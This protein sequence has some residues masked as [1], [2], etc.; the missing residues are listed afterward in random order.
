MVSIMQNFKRNQNRKTL[1]ALFFAFIFGCVAAYAQ[2]IAVTGTVYDSKEEPVIG[3]TVSVVGTNKGVMTDIDGHFTIKTKAGSVLA[4]RYVGCKPQN[5]KVKNAGPLNITLEDN[6]QELNEVVVTAMG[7]TR[8]EKSL[9][10]ARQ[11]INPEN[12][13]ETRSAN[14]LDMLS[15]K[16]AGMQIISGGGPTASTRVVIRGLNSITGNN[17]PLYVIDGVPVMN[18]NGED[19]ELDFGNAVNAI[20]PDEIENIEVL[21]GANAS[22]LYGS[23]AANGVVLIT[24][25]KAAKANKGLGVTY[26]FN[27]MFGHLYNFPTYQNIY[28]TGQNGLFE[29]VST[30][31]NHYGAQN[32]QI[33]YDPNLPYFIYNPNMAGQSPNSWGMPMLGFEIV[34]RDGKVKPYSPNPSTIED[35]YQ[36]STMITNNVSIERKFDQGS[37]RLSYNNV[38]SDD[39]L[40]N[41][42]KLNRHTFNLRATAD[43]A[44]WVSVDVN[45]RYQYESVD[46]RAYRNASDR[47]PIYAIIGLA[48]DI[49]VAELTPWKKEDGTPF[50]FQGFNNPYWL[51]NEVDNGDSRHWFM[52]NLTLNFTITNFLKL[53]GR[54]ATDIQNSEGWGFTNMNTTFCRDGDYNNW[55]RNRSNNNFDALLMFNK[56]FVDNKFNVSANVGTSYQEIKGSRLK[57]SVTMLQFP[58]IKSLSNNKGQILSIQ[59][60]EWKKKLAVYGMAS[61]GWDNWAFLDLTARNE[62]S[63]TL[64]EKNNSYFYWS[65]GAGLV[66]NTLFKLDAHKFPYI[67]IRGSYA[68]VGN[69]T[70]Y[71]KLVSG[72]YKAEKNNTF[73]GISYYIGDDLLKT[74]DLK[75]ERTNSW[76]VGVD[77]R[78]LDGRIK[79]DAT[80]YSKVTRDQIIEADAPFASGYQKEMLNAGKMTNKGVELSLTATPLL[81]KN[82]S[83]I[84]TVNWSKNSNK[85]IELSPG[86]ERYEIGQAQFIKSYAEVGKS[87][88]VFYGNDFKRDENGNILVSTNGMAKYEE[89]QYLGE[90]QPDWFGGWSNTF[91]IFDFDLGFAIDFQKGGKVWSYTAFE[92]ARHGQTVQSLEGRYEYLLSK[93]ILGEDEIERWGFVNPTYTNDPNA[94]L[95]SHYYA[96]GDRSK[97]IYLEGVYDS[98]A[99]PELAGKKTVAWVRPEDYWNHG[100]RASARRYIYDASYVKLREISVGYNIPSKWLRKTK[101]LR[102]ARISFVGRNVAILFQNTPKG[103]D[104]QATSSTGNAQGFERGFNLPMATYGFDIKVTF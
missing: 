46:H 34:G 6:S 88:G 86:V 95:Y 83:W 18:N 76:E 38:H 15:G 8:D 16:A 93:L 24:T 78:F 47:N 57:S 91:K 20:N 40:R 71:D 36:T 63:S 59:E 3:A 60:N 13:T 90:I 62:W 14:L 96:D 55:K 68:Q 35:M 98:D 67:K 41:V 54:A 81:F 22:A 58:D 50:T 4:I 26:N 104:P 84:T 25:K 61:L 27:M 102:S 11:A 48:R 9:S 5:I 103:L 23:D 30:A 70:G 43:L 92:G 66:L 7:I 53:R 87:Y 17:E 65:A 94:T 10:Y 31:T 97:G 79:F 89:N 45:A 44:K 19:G 32:N 21:K 72:Y 51:L 80:Y 82:F 2:E 74:M 85:V 37:F 101:F 69:D 42:N 12:M 75:P 49:S 28:G 73:N 52:G 100:Y 64:P 1:V 99:G 56:T 29:K 39:I 33:S 77:L